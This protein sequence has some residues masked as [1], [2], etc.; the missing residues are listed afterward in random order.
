MPTLSKS[1]T[2]L[3]VIDRLK[4]GLPE[5]AFTLVGVRADGDRFKILTYH[6]DDL[7]DDNLHVVA[8]EL[9]EAVTTGDWGDYFFKGMELCTAWTP[10][11]AP[12]FNCPGHDSFKW[13]AVKLALEAAEPEE[14]DQNDD[15]LLKSVYLGSI[16]HI[17]PSRQCRAPWSS[18][19]PCPFCGGSGNFPNVLHDARALELAEK[20]RARITVRNRDAGLLFTAWSQVDKDEVVRLDT[21]IRYTGANQTCSFCGGEGSRV[22]VE[23]RDFME[24]LEKKAEEIGGFIDG[25]EGDGCDVLIK[26]CV[27]KPEE[28]EESVNEADLGPEDPKEHEVAHDSNAESEH[29]K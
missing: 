11:G 10:V 29:L 17:I 13:E 20:C 16:L 12:Q 21:E 9:R 24:Y 3:D 25:S 4:A 22:L 14:D 6:P 7:H 18:V 27:P 15:H 2:L 1:I 28:P 19:A 5:D 26:K 8:E 23:D